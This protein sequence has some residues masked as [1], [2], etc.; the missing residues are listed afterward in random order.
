ML[1]ILF[2]VHE[3]CDNFCQRYIN[4][5]KGKM[6]IDLVIDDRDQRAD[7]EGANGLGLGPNMIP[8]NN[9]RSSSVDASHHSDNGY[10]P[11]QVRA[12]LNMD[13]KVCT[14]RP[15][16]FERRNESAGERCRRQRATQRCWQTF[17]LLNLTFKG[18]PSKTRHRPNAPKVLNLAILN[19]SR[20]QPVC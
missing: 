12:D 1:F 20:K 3:L 16:W 13:I 9:G 4:C 17:A 10:T 6:P 15:F 5:L 2:Q 7:L 8:M 14:V 11:D 19:R 18:K